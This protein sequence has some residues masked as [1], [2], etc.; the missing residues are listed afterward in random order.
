METI[1]T[2]TEE[3][4]KRRRRSRRKSSKEVHERRRRLK[5]LGLWLLYGAAGVVV[6]TTIAIL[7]GESSG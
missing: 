7:A 3:Q 6:A 2:T 1:S 5:N 4:P